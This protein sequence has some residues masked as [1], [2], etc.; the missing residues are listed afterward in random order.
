MKVQCKYCGLSFDKYISEIQKTNNDFCSRSCAARYNNKLYPKRK[1]E[2]RC[3]VC[4]SIIPAT[5]NFCSGTC[6]EQYGLSIPKQSREEKK[7]VNKK[8]VVTYRQKQK[9][10]AIEYKGGKCELCGYNKSVWALCFHHININEKEFNI[11]QVTYKWTKLKPELDK[12]MLLCMNCH[13]ELHAELKYGA[14]SRI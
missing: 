1:P 5:K 12:C 9:K 14:G 10:K 4:K 7:A 8:A 13:A 3:R 11:S 2:G 6:K